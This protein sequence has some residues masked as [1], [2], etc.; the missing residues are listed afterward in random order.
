MKTRNALRAHARTLAALSL[1][2][3]SALASSNAFTPVATADRTI[4]LRVMSYNVH[5][6]IGMDKRLDLARIAAVIKEHRPDLVALQEVDRGVERTKRV[7]QIAE[8]ARLTGMEYAFAHN[9]NYQGGHYGVAVLS[10]LPILAIDHRRYANLREAERRGLLRVEVSKGGARIHFVNTHLDY[11]HADGRLYE[12]QQLLAA[13]PSTLE[14]V[15]IAGDFNDEPTGAS[16][17]LITTR[18]ADAWT[19][20]DERDERRAGGHAGLTYPADKPTKR[21]DY[22]FFDKSLV[23]ARRARVPHTTASD[24]LP[25]VVDL[26]IKVK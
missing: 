4:R 24:H 5:V 7:D 1:A 18:F 8:L 2:C 19:E 13:L 6:G 25:L 21:I 26:E 20:S 3:L 14:P 10:R 23:R 17:K 22:I 12:T 16:Y 9:L 11:Q 15:I